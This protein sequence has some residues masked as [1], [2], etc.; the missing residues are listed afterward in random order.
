MYMIKHV[1]Q[2]STASKKALEAY[3][4]KKKKQK[5]LY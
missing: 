2:F 5:T 4:K 1:L 3:Q